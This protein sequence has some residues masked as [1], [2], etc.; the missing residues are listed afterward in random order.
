M[1]HNE[2]I[3]HVVLVTWQVFCKGKFKTNITAIVE[4][5]TY[6]Q[7][8]RRIADAEKKAQKEVENLCGIDE[9][10]QEVELRMQSP[11]HIYG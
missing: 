2:H 10:S 9:D 11:T 5:P 6:S 3:S 4:T 1:A 7:L 8:P